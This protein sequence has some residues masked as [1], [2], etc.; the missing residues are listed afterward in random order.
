MRKSEVAHLLLLTQWVLSREKVRVIEVAGVLL[1]FE[2]LIHNLA[3]ERVAPLV[4]KHRLN[5]LIFP[6]LY[7]KR[8]ELGG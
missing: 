1:S 8:V 5:K 2:R 4:L 7:I 6:L 3:M